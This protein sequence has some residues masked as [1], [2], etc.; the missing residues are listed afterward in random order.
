VLPAHGT[1]P[2][3]AFTGGSV[4]RPALAMI[5]L[6]AV[7]VAALWWTRRRSLRATSSETGR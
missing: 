6:L 3:T 1:R 4:T 2:G 5:G 7:G